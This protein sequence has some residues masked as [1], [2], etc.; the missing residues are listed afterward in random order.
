MLM[1]IE[2]ILYKNRSTWKI[3][4]SQSVKSGLPAACKS[5]SARGRDNF[6]EGYLGFNTQE[7]VAWILIS[8]EAR[9]HWH[10]RH[11]DDRHHGVDGWRV[12]SEGKST[13]I[14]SLPWKRSWYQIHQEDAEVV[15]C[16]CTQG[17]PSF[18]ILQSWHMKQN[19]PHFLFWRVR[20]FQ[21]SIS[22]SALEIALG[23]RP[24][25]IS[26]A[27]GCKIPAFGKSLGPRGV[28]FPIHPSSRQCTDPFFHHYQGTIDFVA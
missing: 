2:L 4:G 26:R 20:T 17:G 27:S 21:I 28:Y 22:I 8:H 16:L 6:E 1:C 11:Y 18:I 9:L 5:S 12:V 14:S 25:A 23:L 15:P 3:S 7:P 19:F 10:R 13:G 24:R